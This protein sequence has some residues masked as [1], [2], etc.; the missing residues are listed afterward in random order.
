MPKV[1]AAHTTPA[2]GNIFEDLGFPK[3]EARVMLAK[4]DLVI[5]IKR[6]IKDAGWTQV[7][8]AKAIGMTQS[9]LSKLFNG[10][11]DD[12]SESKLYDCLTRLGCNIKVTIDSPAKRVTTP[13]KA[14]QGHFRIV[15]A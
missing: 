15:Y 10:D 1:R 4:A 14:K 3:E 7:Q 8:A 11:F 9:R 2:D 12:V 5:S 6:M 13:G